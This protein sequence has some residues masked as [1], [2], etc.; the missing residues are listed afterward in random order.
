[1][2]QSASEKYKRNLSSYSCNRVE[3]GAH[4]LPPGLDRVLIVL[5]GGR[6]DLAAFRAAS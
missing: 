2:E 5:L 4:S 3:A 6:E 1:L